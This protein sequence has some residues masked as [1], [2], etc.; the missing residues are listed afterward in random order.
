MILFSGC[1]NALRCVEVDVHKRPNTNEQSF[2]SEHC[3]HEEEFKNYNK[4]LLATNLKSL[5]I[6]V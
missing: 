1:N 4:M 5:L 6:F 2:I 3:F